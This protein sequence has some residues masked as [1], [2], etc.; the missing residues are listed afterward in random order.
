MTK[1]LNLEEI[2]TQDVKRGQYLHRRGYW[3]LV[4]GNP[5]LDPD[6]ADPAWLIQVVNPKGD[7]EMYVAPDPTIQASSVQPS[8]FQ[9]A[10]IVRRAA[11]LRRE[12]AA[13]IEQAAKLETFAVDV[14]RGRWS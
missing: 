8:A 1:P 7:S 9:H 14:D 6:H 10:T 4:I 11:V 2:P 12:A 5:V 3:Y 13:L